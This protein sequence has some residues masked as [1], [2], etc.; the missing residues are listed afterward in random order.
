MGLQPNS[1]YFDKRTR[2]DVAFVIAEVNVH[3]ECV[4]PFHKHERSVLRSVLTTTTVYLFSRHSPDLNLLR[5]QTCGMAETTSAA[6]LA[7]VS[8]IICTL[9]A[10]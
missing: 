9:T 10:S 7:Q 6:G 5:L 1:P 4:L 2:Q 3:D 8:P